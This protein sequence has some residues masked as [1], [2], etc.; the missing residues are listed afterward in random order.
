MIAISLTTR[1]WT[2]RNLCMRTTVLN[3]CMYL[4]YDCCY[5]C[6]WTNCHIS[7]YTNN[8]PLFVF[9]CDFT[10]L[11]CGSFDLTTIG[12]MHININEWFVFCFP[13]LCS[14]DRPDKKYTSIRCCFCCRSYVTERFHQNHR[15]QMGQRTQKWQNWL[16]SCGCGGSR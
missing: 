12:V 4:W 6:D 14:M 11:C 8:C 13:L 3:V 5:S 7:K 16:F 10:A 9:V 15:S 1:N 2:T